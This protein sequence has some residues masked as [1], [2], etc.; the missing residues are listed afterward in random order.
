MPTFKERIEDLS[1]TIPATADGEQFVKDGVHDVIHRMTVVAPDH[2]DLFSSE[3]TV[4][5]GGTSVDS[6]HILGVHRDSSSCR[7]IGSASR[8]SAVD[9]A[10]INYATAADPVYYILDQKIYVK[11]ASGSTVQASIVQEGAVTNWDGGGTSAIAS[12]PDDNYHQ[13]IMYAAMQV[14]HHR[15]VVSTMPT[16]LTLETTPSLSI[17]T[18][19]PTAPT[20]TNLTYIAPSLGT[21][22]TVNYS[23]PSSAIDVSAITNANAGAIL[24]ISTPPAYN[25]GAVVG[26]S[27]STLFWN[28]AELTVN[29]LSISVAPPVPP[30]VPDFTTPAPAIQ[31]ATGTISKTLSGNAPI[32]TSPVALSISSFN[33]FSSSFANLSV[34][35]VPPD[36]PVADIP[37]YVPPTIAGGSGA[38]DLSD[39]IDSSWSSLDFDFDDENIDFATWFQ[40]AGAMIQN[41]EDIE[42]ASMQL[43]K[44]AAYVNTYSVA[45]QN[46]LHVFNTKLQDHS[47]AQGLYQAELGQYQ[48]EVNAQIGEY[49]QNLGKLMQT[50]S[51]EQQN[52]LARYGAELQNN[53]NVF[54]MG[55]AEYQ[56]NIQRDMAELQ[57]QVQADISKMN[58]ST[59]VDIQAKSQVLQEQSSEFTGALSIYQAQLQQYQQDVGKEVQQYQANSQKDMAIHQ[60]EQQMA[61][62]QHGQLMQDAMNLF[63]DANAEYQSTLQEAIQRAQ[64]ENST[65]LSNMQ[66][67]LQI[68]IRNEDK[69]QER[70]L[71]NAVQTT[72]AIV[73]DNGNILA[74][75]QA[76]VQNASQAMSDDAAN[77]QNDL[78][79]YQAEIGAYQQELSAEMGEYGQNM[80]R[81]A[82]K[83][84]SAIQDFGAKIQ[85]ASGEYQWLQGQLAMVAQQYNQ[86]FMAG[87]PQGVQ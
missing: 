58:K 17:S 65:N 3:V 84:S 59:D 57:S 82:E 77:N 48:Q 12:F 56:A 52:E 38:D 66:K 28:L 19:I 23:G 5:D 16:D 24:G 80:Q 64:L 61:L 67:D 47:A 40:A 39:M 41:Q 79:K 37:V 76:E 11:P 74:K 75:Y 27:D 21:I 20:L 87:Q 36:V 22:N 85:K 29:D 10:S 45:I 83:N 86:S 32:Y 63:N 54:N 1:G 62:Q 68:A 70:V 72:Q 34:T 50:W 7:L 71:T 9:S 8:H 31:S 51:G 14:L 81:V 60:T 44:I 53:L 25:G 78:G 2:A 42:L 15:M 35:A 18:T 49:T 55:N 26:F 69:D 43:Q 4:V 13:V 33:T 6:T 46:R 30:V 73:A